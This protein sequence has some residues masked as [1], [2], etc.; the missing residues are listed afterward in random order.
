MTQADSLC[1]KLRT[2]ASSDKSAMS[3]LTKQKSNKK[4]EIKKEE[5]QQQNTEVGYHSVSL[6]KRYTMNILFHEANGFNIHS[7]CSTYSTHH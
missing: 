3:E 7:F 6:R 2:I 5:P 1:N 4:K